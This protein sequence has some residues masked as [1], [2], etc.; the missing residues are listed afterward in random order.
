MIVLN[1]LIH[2]DAYILTQQDKDLWKQFCSNLVHSEPEQSITFLKTLEQLNKEEHLETIMYSM[3]L[4]DISKRD[5]NIQR[6]IKNMTNSVAYKTEKLMNHYAQLAQLESF[7]EEWANPALDTERFNKQCKIIKQL[8]I[9]IS[10]M[11]GTNKDTRY[12]NSQLHVKF[13]EL[14]AHLFKALKA[15]NILNPKEKL[16][17]F[18]EMLQVH[19]DCMDALIVQNIKN[20]QF[21][22]WRNTEAV[23][24][25]GEPQSVSAM[26][27]LIS[28][29][30]NALINSPKLGEE[31]FLPSGKFFVDAATINVGGS[32][33][34][35][36][37][38]PPLTLEDFLNL[39]RRNSLACIQS[40]IE[41][42]IIAEDHLP[43][44]MSLV[45]QGFEKIQ[46]I[47]QEHKTSKTTLLKPS[48]LSANIN[49]VK[50][51]PKYP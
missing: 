36:F 27:A 44:D 6:L 32:F 35:S 43:A 20:E 41:A 18:K 16:S 37:T 40:T 10:G 8:G 1:Q 25:E 49:P 5:V 13:I 15:N 29:K 30:F 7:I 38:Q 24:E 50:S 2:F 17:R 45:L 9:D 33:D 3:L 22:D 4:P 28:L 11:S 26:Q 14:L 34:R 47:N 23:V 42:K 21:R 12:L 51:V 31:Q 48:D 19:K 46:S 39:F